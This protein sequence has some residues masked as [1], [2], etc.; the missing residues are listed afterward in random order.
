[1]HWKTL[2]KKFK[3]YKTVYHLLV[4]SYYLQ[5]CAIHC[6]TNKKSPIDKESSSINKVTQTVLSSNG[7]LCIAQHDYKKKYI[8]HLKMENCFS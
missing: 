7:S 4:Y 1:M 3:C 2:N 8:S 5:V 6:I